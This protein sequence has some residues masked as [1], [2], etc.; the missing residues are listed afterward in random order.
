MIAVGGL[1]RLCGGRVAQAMWWSHIHFISTLWSNLQDCKISSRAEIPKLERVCQ[2]RKSVNS[3]SL[4][5]A[6]DRSCRNLNVNIRYILEPY[7]LSK[8]L[9]SVRLCMDVVFRGKLKQRMIV[10][11][12]GRFKRNQVLTSCSNFRAQ[13]PVGDQW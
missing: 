10:R 12:L 9:K 4:S 11:L 2:K 8:Y 1:R 7:V 5:L 6:S 3:G 13:D